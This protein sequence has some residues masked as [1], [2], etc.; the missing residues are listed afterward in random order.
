MNQLTIRGF[1]KD[2]ERKLRQVAREQRLSLNKAALFLLRKG[3][4]LSGPGK[5]KDVVGE[6]LDHLIGKWSE[7][8]EKEFLRAVEAFEQIDESIWL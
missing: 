4:G 3:A 6:S 1:D 5:T 2:L 7:E 8:E